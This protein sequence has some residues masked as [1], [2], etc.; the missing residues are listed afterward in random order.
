MAKQINLWSALLSSRFEVPST[1]NPFIRLPEQTGSCAHIVHGWFLFANKVRI[2]T[3]SVGR[4][5]PIT[6]YMSDIEDPH[7]IFRRSHKYPPVAEL[8]VTEFISQL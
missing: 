4:H 5:C 2:S 8:G 3:E 6:R 7:D 1:F